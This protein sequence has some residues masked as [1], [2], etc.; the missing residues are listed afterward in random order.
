MKL[1]I[2]AGGK[3]RLW[4]SLRAPRCAYRSPESVRTPWRAVYLQGW[5]AGL[6]RR[7]ELEVGLQLLALPRSQRGCLRDAQT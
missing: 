4:F 1:R 3:V 6:P 2:P 5:R 7:V